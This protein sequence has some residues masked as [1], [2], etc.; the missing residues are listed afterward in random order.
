MHVLKISPKNQIAL[1]VDICKRLSLNAGDS[2]VLCCSGDVIMLKKLA[3][4]TVED[5]MSA[6]TDTQ[7]WAQ[8]EGYTD[9]DVPGVM[10]DAEAVLR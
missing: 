10:R 6:L 8:S 1:P 5:F 3:M 2:L 7:K 4:P 9:E